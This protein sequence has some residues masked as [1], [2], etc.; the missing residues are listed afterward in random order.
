VQ[1]RADERRNRHVFS[2]LVIKRNE[3]WQKGL[4]S[5]DEL[6]KVSSFESIVKALNEAG[7]RYLVVGGVAVNAYGYGRSTFDLDLVVELRPESVKKTFKALDTIGYRPMIPVTAEQFGNEE[8]RESYI[9]DKGMVVLQFFSDHHPE[10]KLDVFVREPFDFEMEYGL[11]RVE[12]LQPGA[13]VR[14]LRLASLVKMKLE[15]SRP[16]DREDIENLKLIYGEDFQ[17]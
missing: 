16:K 13:P 12:E 4:S 2:I 1:H 5:Q 8:I 17:S 9:R 10:T 6:V 11:A 14:L 7:V 15:A 3:T